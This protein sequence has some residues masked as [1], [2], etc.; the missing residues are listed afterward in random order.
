VVL[1]VVMTV[2][3]KMKTD[4]CIIPYFKQRIIYRGD[5]YFAEGHL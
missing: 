2:R 1:V 4:L 5:N 3:I